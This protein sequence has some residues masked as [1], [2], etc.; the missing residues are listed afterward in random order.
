MNKYL[1]PRNVMYAI[2]IILL[3]IYFNHD[4]MTHINQI[5]D[6]FKSLFNS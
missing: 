5:I 3:I 2:T 4:R 1:T 6:T